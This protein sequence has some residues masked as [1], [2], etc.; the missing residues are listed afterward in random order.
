MNG[1]GEGREVGE[2]R[3]ESLNCSQFCGKRFC[4]HFFPCRGVPCSN[5]RTSMRGC[6]T[7]QSRACQHLGDDRPAESRTRR[8]YLF[9]GCFDVFTRRNNGP[10]RCFEWRDDTQRCALFSPPS[11]QVSRSPTGDNERGVVNKLD[12]AIEREVRPW[13]D[14]VDS[15][16]AQG[17]QDEL[18]L[19]QVNKLPT[20]VPVHDG[21]Y[22]TTHH[23]RLGIR[24]VFHTSPCAKDGLARLRF[25]VLSVCLRDRGHEL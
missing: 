11:R 19:P 2:D 4:V 24:N 10:V 16:R 17:I 12:E 8:C 18:S 14:L 13:L 5:V 1:F 15:L 6:F 20:W 21:G 7:L 22:H 9:H 25:S 23:S 3:K